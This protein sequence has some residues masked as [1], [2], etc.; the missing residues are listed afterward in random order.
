MAEKRGG[1]QSLNDPVLPKA[2]TRFR[3]PWTWDGKETALS[4]RCTDETGYVQ[5]T[6][7]QLVA[8]RGLNGTDHHNGIKTWYIHADGKV[9]HE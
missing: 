7:E 8:V 1:A 4:S 3:F 2:L 5:P 6:R 9:S